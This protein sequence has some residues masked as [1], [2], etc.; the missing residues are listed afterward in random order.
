MGPAVHRAG[1]RIHSVFI[2]RRPAR[3]GNVDIPPGPGPGLHGIR[4]SQVV[5]LTH[6]ENAR[7]CRQ[8]GQ[9]I[10]G[11]QGCDALLRRSAGAAA[12]GGRSVV[13]LAF[14]ARLWRLWGQVLNLHFFHALTPHAE[15]VAP[16]V[17]A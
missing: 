5:Q 2:R 6:W 17:R 7:R 15:S 10:R 9:D 8:Q 14:G 1:L 3:G 4:I 16:G 11:D 13:E 12:A